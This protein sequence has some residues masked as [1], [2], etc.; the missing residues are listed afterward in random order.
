MSPAMLKPLTALF[1]AFAV[2][3][4]AIV[5]VPMFARRP[6]RAAGRASFAAAFD[7]PEAVTK[8]RWPNLG[9]YVIAHF[10]L[11]ALLAYY[12]FAAW[13]PPALLTGP[14]LVLAYLVGLVP[15]RRL[16]VALGPRDR[17]TWANGYVAVMTAGLLGLMSLWWFVAHD[18]F[19]LAIRPPLSL[20]DRDSRPG[21]LWRSA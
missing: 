10:C 21:P 20:A 13:R 5:A 8:P 9:V 17:R 7:W 18:S 4:G 12:G 15:G 19:C 14:G 3:I 1:L 6:H 2:V 11:V 16:F